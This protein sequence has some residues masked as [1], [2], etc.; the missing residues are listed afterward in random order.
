MR[1]KTSPFNNRWR[2]LL[3]AALVAP[4]I[5]T[6]HA[7]VALPGPLVTVQWLNEHQADVQ[8]VDVRDDLNTLS[9]KPTFTTTGGKRVLEQVG[10]HIP[11]ALSVNFWGLRTKREVSGKT[12]DFQLVSGDEF[13]ARMRGVQLEPGKPIVIT[14]TGDDATSLQE[15]AFFAW[16]LQVYGVPAEQISILNGGVHAWIAADLPLDTDAIAPL[17]STQWTA[18][19][20]RADMLADRTQVQAAQLSGKA[21]FDVRPLTQFAGLE[22]PPAGLVAGRLA[23]SRPLPA[24]IF[25]KQAADGSWRFLTPEENRSL[26]SVDGIPRPKK[27]ILYCNTG[28][29][30]AGAWFALERVQGLSGVRMFPGGVYEWVKLGL[31]LDQR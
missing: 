20:P 1:N 11:D 3:A 10:G 26:F 21:I 15:A 30:A 23:G 17:G 9:A 5:S 13:Q 2:A 24:E 16:V 25:Y 6:A 12:L 14:P 31:P 27:G 19:T 4:C 28:Q 8:V 18:K 29:Y 7:A 22:Q